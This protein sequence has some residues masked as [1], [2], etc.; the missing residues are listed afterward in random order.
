VSTDLAKTCTEELPISGS[1]KE[2]EKLKRLSDAKMH[3]S[4][5]ITTGTGRV[6]Q[7]FNYNE[8]CFHKHIHSAERFFC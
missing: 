2:K 1:E 6:F 5:R 3:H 8:I 7:N 4:I